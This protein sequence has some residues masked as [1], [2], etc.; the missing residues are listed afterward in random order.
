MKVFKEGVKRLELDF[1]KA[2]RE[3]YHRLME[4]KPDTKI[5]SLLFL[6]YLTLTLHLKLLTA[7]SF[8][9]FPLLFFKLPHSQ[10]LVQ[11]SSVISQS[12]F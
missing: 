4:R 6:S 1:S 2:H 8:L 11:K 10:G 12:Y 9:I 5:L 3:L 7:A